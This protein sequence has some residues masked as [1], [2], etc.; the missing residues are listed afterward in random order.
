[1]ERIDT[2]IPPGLLEDKWEN[3]K[4]SQN[5][6]NPGN[7]G[8]MEIIVAVIQGHVRQSVLKELNLQ[9]LPG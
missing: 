8:K 4:A 2:K 6:I 9:L 5:L 1:M 3:Y 7:K